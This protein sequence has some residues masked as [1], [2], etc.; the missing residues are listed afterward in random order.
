[1][2]TERLPEILAPDDRSLDLEK[3]ALLLPELARRADADGHGTL[4]YMLDMA[5]L[6]ARQLAER[7]DGEGLRVASGRVRR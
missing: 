4:A 2:S 5:A 1:M 3:L 6:E 7:L